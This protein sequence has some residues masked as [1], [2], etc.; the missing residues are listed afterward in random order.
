MGGTAAPDL[1]DVSGQDPV[2][3]VRAAVDAPGGIG[4]FVRKA[5][6]VHQLLNVVAELTAPPLHTAESWYL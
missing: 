6:V 1:V 4:H 5:K 3:M 2:A